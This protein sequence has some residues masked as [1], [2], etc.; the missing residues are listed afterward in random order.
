MVLLYHWHWSQSHDADDIINSTIPFLMSK[1][2][3]IRNS[4][5]LV[6][7]CHWHKQQV[8]LMALSMAPLHLLG[9]D[10]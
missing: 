10:D 9:Q 7:C 8:M 5:T 4:M 2:I 3:E 1:M 6:M